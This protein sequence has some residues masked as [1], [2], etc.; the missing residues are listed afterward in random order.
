MQRA[1]KEVNQS[2]QILFCFVRIN[3]TAIREPD[4][5]NKSFLVVCNAAT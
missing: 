5:V 4:A 1:V 3:L 2:K